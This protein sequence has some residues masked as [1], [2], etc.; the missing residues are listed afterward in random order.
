VEWGA[1]C[2]LARRE[3]V[4]V[5]IGRIMCTR[6]WL[7]RGLRLIRCVANFVMPEVTT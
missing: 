2:T 6:A 7:W 1:I 3:R 4:S 5:N